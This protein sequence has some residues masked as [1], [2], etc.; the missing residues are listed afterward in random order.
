MDNDIIKGQGI[1]SGKAIEEC[2]KQGLIQISPFNKSQLNP[3]SY[4]LT[5]GEGVR[6]YEDVS[7]ISKKDPIGLGGTEIHPVGNLHTGYLDSKKSN[8]TVS[9]KIGPKGWL[10]RP[11]IGYLM[12][13]VES[14][15]TDHFV[16]V[17]DGKS[18]MGRLFTLVHYT[19][20]YVDPGFSGQYTLEV[21]VL[22]P[23]VVYA[24]Q[25][26]GQLRFHTISGEVD[27][28]KGHYSGSTAVGA[29]AS[30]AYE[31]FD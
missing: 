16:P 20:G 12:H 14:V 25:R 21:S 11:G 15:K 31:Q 5:L 17:I 28:Y 30:H 7:Y 10:L 13:T 3:A 6:V 1:L 18:S 24:G 22:H 2:V 19:A 4:D 8:S 23:T 26:V 9:F 27:L 29:V